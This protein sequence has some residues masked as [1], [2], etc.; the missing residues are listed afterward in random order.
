MGENAVMDMMTLILLKGFLEKK[1]SEEGLEGKSA[2]D[3]AVDNGFE[4]TEEEWLE[5]LK[6]D[7]VD[8]SEYLK[9]TD[10]LSTDEI[11]DIIR[12]TD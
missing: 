7:N 6:G 5:S 11:I 9:I 1:I 12:T 8:L 4:G 2:Y 3:I 10:S